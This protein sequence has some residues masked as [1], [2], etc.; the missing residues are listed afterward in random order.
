MRTWDDYKN[1]VK[2]VD[3]EIAEDIK[4]VE[5]VS[6][7]VSAMVAQRNAKGLSQRELAAMCGIPQSTVAR[8]KS[9]ETVPSLKILLNIFQRLDL[10]LTVETKKAG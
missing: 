2:A 10:Q 7:I 6:T 5:S 9:C 1:H 8:I 3:P 4:E